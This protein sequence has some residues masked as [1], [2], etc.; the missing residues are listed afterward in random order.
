MKLKRIP[1]KLMLFVPVMA[2][3][4][5]GMA[6]MWAAVF[7]DSGVAMLCVLNAVRLLYQ[8]KKG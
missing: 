6:S 7:A 4:L 1:I 8:G 2:L 3:G 5:L